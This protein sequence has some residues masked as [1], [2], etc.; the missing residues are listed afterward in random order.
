MKNP[1][2]KLFSSSEPVALAPA[3]VRKT[4]KDIV[5]GFQTTINDLSALTQDNVYQLNAKLAQ[6]ESLK[7]EADALSAEAT[8]A[9]KIAQNLKA[10]LS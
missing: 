2:K 9:D 10:L 5:A 4:L 8:A 6:A 7:L 3:P 1:F